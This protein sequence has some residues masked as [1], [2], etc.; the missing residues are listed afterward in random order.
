MKIQKNALFALGMLISMPLFGMK[1]SYG[2]Y[3]N[4]GERI[5]EEDRHFVSDA[6]DFF[7]VYDGHGGEK[8][9]EYAKNNVHN[10]YQNATGSIENKLKTSFEKTSDDFMQ[11]NPEEKSGSTAIVGA[12]QGNKICFAHAGDSRAMLI[13]N[14]KFSCTE[15]HK[16]KNEAEA[17][18]IND[19]I[20]AK[21][22]TKAKNV[23]NAY[24][25]N[26]DVMIPVLGKKDKY[27]RLSMTRSL[28]DREFKEYGVIATPETQAIELQDGDMIVLA[29]DGLW[30]IVDTKIV[31]DYVCHS[32]LETSE[33]DIAKGLGE[34]VKSG[35]AA[36]KNS[37]SKEELEKLNKSYSLDNLTIIVVCVGTK[38]A[39]PVSFWSQAWNSLTAA[40]TRKPTQFRSIHTK[41]ASEGLSYKTQTA[42]G[43]GGVTRIC[44]KM[45]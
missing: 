36:Y 39:P 11:N 1:V 9:A 3:Y 4:P 24:T 26:A 35:F 8:M 43:N 33:T 22:K 25:T 13:R 42:A 12:I 5:Y 16:T 14:N 41:K 37:L 10:N 7:A 38:K 29:S 21:N 20:C 6:K 23:K 31:S 17:L 30:D 40:V 44:A 45:F 32:S 19:I 2:V 18:R 34:K 27:N 15:D 28:G